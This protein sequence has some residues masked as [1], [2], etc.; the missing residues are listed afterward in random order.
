MFLIFL[1]ILELC[2]DLL[3]WRTTLISVKRNALVVIMFCYVSDFSHYST[4]LCR[5]TV[6]AYYSD[7]C[8][9]KCF[10][11][12]Y[13][14]LSFRFFSL[15][16]SSAS[17]KTV[18]AYYSNECQTQSFSIYYV[19]LFCRLFSLLQ[20]SVLIIPV[21]ACYSIVCHTQ[22]FSI[23]YVSLFCRLFLL[24]QSSISIRD[25]SDVLL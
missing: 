19:S 4:A 14:S 9:A 23:Y 8:Q 12:C 3:F 22:R 7:Q 25:C 21:L 6:L 11:S 18:L 2:V 20:S 10:S 17:I 16:Q 24:L 5:S 1:I 13:V 15:F